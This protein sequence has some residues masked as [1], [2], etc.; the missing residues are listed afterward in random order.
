MCSAVLVASLADHFEF[1]L[2]T[3]QSFK[4][5][6]Q[7]IRKFC[8]VPRMGS[9]VLLGALKYFPGFQGGGPPTLGRVKIRSEIASGKLT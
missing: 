3:L 2:D 8:L 7:T 4:V 9:L 1:L 6:P 5:G